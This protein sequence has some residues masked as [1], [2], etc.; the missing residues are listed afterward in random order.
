[1]FQPH[2]KRE[3][4]AYLLSLVKILPHVQDSTPTV[5]MQYYACYFCMSILTHSFRYLPTEY[6][7]TF[8]YN[9]YPIQILI[10]IMC[11]LNCCSGQQLIITQLMIK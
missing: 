1:M 9:T 5:Q 4:A 10:T 11:S 6:I 7:R 2:P 3:Q 8:V